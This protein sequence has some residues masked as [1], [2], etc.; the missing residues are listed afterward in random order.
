MEA[1]HLPNLFETAIRQACAVVPQLAHVDPARILVLAHKLPPTRLGQTIGFRQ[2]RRAVRA[3]G[4]DALYAI[5]FSAGLLSVTPAA[6][7]G[8]P[9]YD[10][11]FLALDTVMHELWHVAP[12]CD[13]T[14]RPMRHGATFD[15]I[16]RTM[17]RAYLKKGG[18]P[19][20]VLSHDARVLMRQMDRRARFGEALRVR[21]R[22]T[23]LARLVPTMVEYMCP[24][25]HVTAR[26][27]RLSR[28]S[29]CAQCCS[30]FD[31]RYLLRPVA[32]N[33]E[34]ARN[35]EKNADEFTNL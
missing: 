24:F 10:R 22:V 9:A 6:G 15:A 32:T 2:Q 33:Y 26:H 16:V 1:V 5:G 7:S 23:T 29:S 3:E 30:R 13:G 31:A 19:L 4:S 21:E 11:E 8:D 20:P 18:E 34:C 25:G 14:I 12:A 35:Y 28:A 17:R 27:R